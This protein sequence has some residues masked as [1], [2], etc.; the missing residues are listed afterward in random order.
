MVFLNVT[1]ELRFIKQN[2]DAKAL[3]VGMEPLLM[4]P[5]NYDADLLRLSDRYMGYRNFADPGYQG[6]FEPYTFPVYPRDRVLQEFPVSV[7]AVRDHD[8]CIFANHDPNIRQA[9]GNAVL[10]HK[11]ILAGPLFQN[12]VRDKLAVQRRCRFELITENDI[13]DY[14]FSEKLGESLAAGCVP[15]YYGCT[16]IKEHVPSEFYI[17]MGDFVGTD[18]VP[19]IR[20]VLEHGLAPGVYETHYERIADKALGLLTERFSIETCL[21]E[22]VQRFVDELTANGWR[23]RHRSWRWRSSIRKLVNRQ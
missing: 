22:P 18:G 7:S 19:D 13:N 3:V 6:Q 4:Y 1:P 11:S 9:L 8:F 10:S 5:P 17:D 16:R 14:Y 20:R 21:I 15:V 12:R 23:S 2:T